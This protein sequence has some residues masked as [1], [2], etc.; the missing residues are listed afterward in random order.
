MV[1][2]QFKEIVED[3][4]CEQT[5]ISQMIITTSE[6]HINTLTSQHHYEKLLSVSYLRTTNHIDKSHITELKTRQ[7]QAQNKNQSSII[8]CIP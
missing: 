5:C 2:K 8:M 4:R 7:L 1:S 6:R 3:D